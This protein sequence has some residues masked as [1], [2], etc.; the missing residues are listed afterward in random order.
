MAEAE[1]PLTAFLEH[2]Y[3]E[4]EAAEFLGAMLSEI[5]KTV[6]YGNIK[7]E[8]RRAQ[9]EP[10]PPESLRLLSQLSTHISSIVPRGF[11]FKI[12]RHF[13]TAFD[14][15]VALTDVQYV[16]RDVLSNSVR[17]GII[18]L[19]WRINEC[20]RF[21]ESS[22]DPQ[23]EPFLQSLQ[24]HPGGSHLSPM[25]QTVETR[26]ANKLATLR[27]YVPVWKTA[28]KEWTHFLS[29]YD[30]VFPR[31]FW[32]IPGGMENMIGQYPKVFWKLFWFT[33]GKKHCC[34]ADFEKYLAN[35]IVPIL[36]Q[37]PNAAYHVTCC[38]DALSSRLT[39]VGPDFAAWGLHPTVQ[40]ALLATG[41][42]IYAHPSE[43]SAV[44]RSTMDMSMARRDENGRRIIYMP[45][46]PPST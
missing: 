29:L 35:T 5:R 33:I 9:Y 7:F 40:L 41:I 3:L 28:L 45:P 14:L 20:I 38:D 22:S 31:V 18:E 30:S 39:E 12:V 34:M 4:K 17:N 21:V 27:S 6:I 46:P 10:S 42:V 36:F 15:A 16:A 24:N 23:L 11:P 2:N 8:V 1:E 25:R 32:D 26:G 37:S 44:T 13:E 19:I 43:L